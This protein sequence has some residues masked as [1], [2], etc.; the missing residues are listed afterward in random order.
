MSTKTKRAF[1]T[2][3]F[4]AGGGIVS[5]GLI[6]VASLPF[7]GTA[8]DRLVYATVVAS[9]I[10]IL[11]LAGM[12]LIAIGIAFRCTIILIKL[13]GKYTI[14]CG[15]VAWVWLLMTL[16]GEKKG[17]RPPRRQTCP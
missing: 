17:L 4:L 9:A 11:A 7:H 16:Y 3:A 10:S 15:Y 13:V 2:L 1:L 14:I 12:A 6:V 5:A 8:S